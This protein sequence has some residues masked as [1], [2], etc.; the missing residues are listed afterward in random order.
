[1]SFAKSKILIVDDEPDIRDL[2][3]YCLKREG[4]DISTA[5]NGE[6]ALAEAARFMPDLILMDVMMP[7]MDGIEA[8][9][10]LKSREDLKN[11]ILVFMTARNEEFTVN[12]AYSAGA[13]DYICKPKKP[14]EI[15]SQVSFIL[16]TKA[17]SA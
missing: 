17:T 5:A 1:M 3:H 10:I 2:L 6:E 8:C 9:S 7:K 11:I 14:Q 13:D 4:Y 12:A 16:K 15:I